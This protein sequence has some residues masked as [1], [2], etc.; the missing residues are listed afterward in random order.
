[1]TIYVVKKKPDRKSG[2]QDVNDLKVGNFYRVF[3]GRVKRGVIQVL[4]EPFQDTKMDELA[5]KIINL[6]TKHKTEIYLSDNGVVPNNVGKWNRLSHLRHVTP[7]QIIA[8][9]A[10]L[11][12]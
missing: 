1:M 4:S 9:Q 2:I 5:I 11:A 8:Y 6:Y 3:S 7:R 12:Q 10:M